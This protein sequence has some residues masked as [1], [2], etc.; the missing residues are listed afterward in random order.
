MGLAHEAAFEVAIAG[1]GPVGLMLAIELGR[2]GVR[3]LLVNERPDTSPHPQANATQA[4]TMEHY[5]RLGFADRIRATGLPPDYPTDICY[6]TRYARHELARFALPSSR[7]AR[8]LVRNLGGSWSAAELPHRGSQMFIERVLR[9]EA[10]KLPSVSLRYGCRL[11]GFEQ[12]EDGVTLQLDPGGEPVRAQ[13]LVGCDGARSGVRRALGIGW[14]GETG[15]RRDFMGGRMM[16]MHF[17]S[18]DL[19]AVIGRPP[20]WMYWTFNA[21]RRSFMAAI[22]GVDAFVFHTQ[23]RSDEDPEAIDDEALKAMFFET[24]GARCELSLLS[25]SSWLAGHALVA[26]RL[27]EGRVFLAG[28]AAHLFTPTGGLGYNTGVEDAVN[29]GWKLAAVLR[30]G[31]PASLLDSYEAERRPAAIRNTGHARGFADSI[32][33][34]VPP[35]GLEDE[36]SEGE[37]LRRQA[38]E[39]LL[40]HAKAEFDIPGITFGT[41]C[42]GSPIVARD[43]EAPPPDRADLYQPTS[44]PGGRAPHAWLPDGGSLFDRLGFGFTLLELAPDE[45]VGDAPPVQDIA[46]LTH[47][48]IVAAEAR[49]A[50]LRDLY[51]RRFTLIRPD[52]VVAWRG[53]RLPGDLRRLMFG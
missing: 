44:I 33:L 35:E 1:G 10:A 9:D 42:D 24:L 12:A 38:G 34:L 50:G 28:D 21:G 48:R 13:W 7:D 25:R 47:L 17:R 8:V 49:A 45:P 39:R 46:G 2:R 41:R 32:G 36:T 14:T 26:E 11:A 16:A 19:Y 37:A 4:R 27:R 51:P 31:A 18:P 3:T 20:A 53:E 6:F 40:A 23:L 43:D 52:Q 29:L 15:I 5:R 22:D 30:E